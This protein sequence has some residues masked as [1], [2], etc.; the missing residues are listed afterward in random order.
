MIR[1]TVTTCVRNDENELVTEWPTSGGGTAR[2]SSTTTAPKF[3]E[4][5]S[6]ISRERID[7]NIIYRKTGLGYAFA[8]K[9]IV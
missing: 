2:V 8:D 5:S 4:R 7:D 9:C 6:G 3:Y 1:S